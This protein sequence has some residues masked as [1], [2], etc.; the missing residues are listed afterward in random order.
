MEYITFEDL[1]QEPDPKERNVNSQFFTLIFLSHSSDSDL[2]VHLGNH[3]K[4]NYIQKKVEIIFYRV[5]IKYCVISKIL[6][7]ILD[8]GLFRFPLGVSCVHNGR[9]KTKAAAEL[10]ELRKSHHFKKKNHNI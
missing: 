7:Y 6:R 3:M 1:I 10:A 9:S 5:L 8:S 2:Q 4:K